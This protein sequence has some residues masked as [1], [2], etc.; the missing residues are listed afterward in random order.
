MQLRQ[1]GTESVSYE[2]WAK[3]DKITKVIVCT[4]DIQ[5]FAHYLVKELQ[6]LKTHAYLTKKQET[7]F[8]ESVKTLPLNHYVLILDFAEN[9]M[10]R[11]QNA[12]SNAFYNYEQA[13]LLPILL[14]FNEDGNVRSQSYCVVSPSMDH[15][16]ATVH[17]FLSLILNQLK[18]ENRKIEFLKIFS[19]GAP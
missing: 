2:R 16:P 13:T 18:S 19:D 1:N 15:C 7:Y 3:V 6:A 10:F 8:H 5:D 14:Y 4:D 12:V 9:F 11:E 17:L